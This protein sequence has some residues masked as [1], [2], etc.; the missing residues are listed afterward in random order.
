MSTEKSPVAPVGAA[1]GNLMRAITQD[2]YGPPDH[3]LELTTVERP[4]TGEGEV[5]VRVNAAPVS[6][7]DWHL[8]RG[9]PY[10][11]RFVTGL[12]K[13]TYLVPGYEM[14]GT[15]EAVGTGVTTFRPGD[16][17]FGW[18][19]GSF[20]EYVSVPVGQLLPKP[21]ALTPDE[22]AA[23]PIAGFTA[24][25]GVRDKGGVGPG[26]KVLITGASG[27]VGTYAVQLAKWLGAE[28]TGVCSTAKMDLVRSIGADHVIDYTREDF[29]DREGQYDVL[30]DLY[31]NP[32][33]VRCRRAL[34]TQ[35]TLVLIGGTG[36]RWFM[37]LDR[38]MRASVVAP[39]LGLKVRPLIHQDRLDD[40]ATLRDL[41]E[42]GE[43]AP[44]LD[45]TFPLDQVAEAI[46]FVTEGRARGQVVVKP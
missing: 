46:R 13:P 9:L 10:L 15:V 34:K 16:E 8:T 28:V 2:R 37:G 6:G 35:G 25:Q 27:G 24:L 36:G 17:V 12:R 5:L 41:I 29:A 19:N 3:V 1:Q 20:A 18:A 4:R 14:S 22:A 26:R 23:V 42:T 43:L 21:A 30:I 32:S 45:R 44:V 31:G 11:A 39:F 40:L 33:I 38:W 7:T